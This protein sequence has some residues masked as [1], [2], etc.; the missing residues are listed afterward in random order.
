MMFCMNFVLGLIIFCSKIPVHMR[1]F[2]IC[3][4]FFIQNVFYIYSN[5]PFYLNADLWVLAFDS[6]PLSF[7]SCV[8]EWPICDKNGL[9]IAAIFSQITDFPS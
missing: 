5:H 6:V 4:L 2:C 8:L 1:Y 3:F 7:F 9:S